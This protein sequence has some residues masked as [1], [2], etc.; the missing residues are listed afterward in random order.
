MLYLKLA[1]EARVHMNIKV[2]I[3]HYHFPL[4]WD[5]LTHDVSR[6]LNS[7]VHELIWHFPCTKHKLHKNL[8]FRLQC[9]FRY[10]GQFKI[11]Q[12]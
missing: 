8:Y 1:L 3:F 9:T 12:A 6:Q 7:M 10:T 4:Y 5:K 2:Y 11:V